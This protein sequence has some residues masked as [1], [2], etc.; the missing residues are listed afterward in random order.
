MKNNHKLIITFT[1]I[2]GIIIGMII[3]RFVFSSPEATVT[4]LKAAHSGHDEHGEEVARL[5]DDE[6]QEFG[7]ELATAGEGNV[8]LHINLTGE[9]KIDPDRLAHIIPRFPGIVKKV[10]KKIGDKIKKYEV[11][12]IIESNE[13]LVPYDVKSL[14]D[15]T[16]IQLHLTLGEVINGAGHDIVV[17]DL[18]YVWADLNIYQKDLQ[19]FEIGQEAVISAGVKMPEVRGKISYIS[20]VVDE[21]T[22]TTIARVVLPNP[23][24]RWRPGLFVNG[25]VITESVTVPVAVPKTALETYEDQTVVFV[26]TDEG[27]KP[28]PVSIGRS[29]RITVELTAGLKSGQVYVSKG[30]FTLKAEL[31]KQSFGEGH[32]H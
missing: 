23:D 19:Y 11:L 2:I 29:N 9:I 32:A 31:Q 25:H 17:A 18:S 3:Q 14:I 4:D 1:L 21:D 22:R 26:K 16:V 10:H 27:F 12:A 20:P 7:I 28:Q 30:G 13:S 8:Q 15:G 6:L 24:G 5:E